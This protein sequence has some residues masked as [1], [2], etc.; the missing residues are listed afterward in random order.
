MTVY[1]IIAESSAVFIEA[2]L[3][4]YFLNKRFYNIKK[5]SSLFWPYMF[6][7]AW[8]IFATFSSVNQLIYNA[9][10][11][12]ILFCYLLKY[13]Q[14]TILQK[15]LG[16]AIVEGLSISTTII[17]MGVLSI[18]GGI[19]TFNMMYTQDMPRLLLII[20]AKAVQ[21]MVFLPLAN[22]HFSFRDI[23]QKPVIILFIIET[24]CFSCLFLIWRF[25]LTVEIS[26]NA[27]YFLTILAVLILAIIVLCFFMHELFVREKERSVELETLIRRKEQESVYIKEMESFYSELRLWKHEYNNNI[28]AIRGCLEEPDNKK[29]IAY[30]DSIQKIPLT[31]KTTLQTNSSALNS[32]VSTKLA[33]AQSQGIDVSIKAFFPKEITNV[34]DSDLCSI[35]GNLLDNAIE[36]CNR[37]SEESDTIKFINFNMR[38][39]GENLIVTVKNSYDGEIKR[40]NDRF[41]SMKRKNI[42]GL[43]LVHI[44]RIVDLYNG[45]VLREYDGRIFTSCVNLP[46]F[47]Y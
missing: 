3:D 23:S 6:L 24:A 14:G 32:V 36:A 30:I 38:L 39:Q 41:I 29:A 40:D 19:S 22:R 8:G 47:A 12:L 21:C 25:I 7:T 28:I 26:L 16:T 44:E 46:M 5:V 37:M 34:T 43:G 17:C 15:A 13:K 2:F 33:M 9:I 4:L 45:T 27:S 42:S 10:Y 31:D 11:C 35:C 20:T 18:T 1:W